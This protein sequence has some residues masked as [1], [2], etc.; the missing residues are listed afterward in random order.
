MKL[1]NISTQKSIAKDA[2]QVKKNRDE[3][4]VIDLCDEILNL[5]ASRQHKFDFLL[6]DLHKNGISRTKLPVDAYYNSLKLVIEYMEKQ[7]NESVKHFD[8]PD[9]MTVSGV[10]RGE[11]RKIYDKRRIE[12]IPKH[13]LDL[14]IISYS[15]F[16]FNNQ[17]KIIRNKISDLN[18]VKSMLLNY[19]KRINKIKNPIIYF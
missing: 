18:K 4:Y 16:N 2:N 14:I 12:E 19:V 10:N 8:K 1:T 3:D 7:H 15:D 5:T 13:G 9:I 6:G 17:K 11:Q